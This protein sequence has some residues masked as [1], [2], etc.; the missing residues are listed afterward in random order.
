MLL[1]KELLFSQSSLAAKSK[2][3]VFCFFFLMNVLS[4]YECCFL[5]KPPHSVLFSRSPVYRVFFFFSVDFHDILA[6]A[7][8]V[9]SF[10]LEVLLSDVFSFVT[11][12]Y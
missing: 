2:S 4:S 12:C 8:A 9:T 6:A 1:L 3:F 10:G 5:P 11:K 7:T